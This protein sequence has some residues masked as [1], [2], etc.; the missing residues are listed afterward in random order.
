MQNDDEDYRKFTD[1]LSKEQ[2]AL[3]SKVEWN[4]ISKE[5]ENT[6]DKN[7]KEK[8]ILSDIYFKLLLN[9]L[10]KDYNN[11]DDEIN[12]MLLDQK[13]NYINYCQI[14]EKI[15]E[16]KEKLES[17][18]KELK[19]EQQDPK[20]KKAVKKE[21]I[22][23]QNN[24]IKE[25]DTLTKN[26]KTIKSSLCYGFIIINFPQ[27]ENDVLKLEKYFTGFQLEYQKPRNIIEEK[28]ASYNITNS[29]FLVKFFTKKMSR[30]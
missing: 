6:E 1:T 30:I 27:N 2:K 21:I 4:D 20:D 29:L 5:A 16:A 22:N 3:L 26:L 19:E 12:K 14:Q 13:N 17:I 7:K 10:N 24:L 25:L 11:T 18:N 23:A 15:G 28:L 8:E 9:E